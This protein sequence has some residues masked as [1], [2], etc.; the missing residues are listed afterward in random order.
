MKILID[1]NHPAHVHYFK[2]MI[3]IMKNSGV[4]FKIISRNKEIEHYLLDQYKISYIDRGVGGS[5][6]FS[7]FIYF[8]YA[9]YF[10]L[11][12]LF[13]FKPDY[14]I[15]FGTPYPAIAS[16]IMRIDH[17]SINDTEHAKLHHFL[18][19]PFSRVI[20]T[21]SCYKGS[22]GKKQIRFNSFMELSYLSDPYFV[23]SENIFNIL[24]INKTDKYVIIRFVSWN[25]VHDKGHTGLTLENKIKAVLEF[26]KYAK[27]FISSEGVLPEK[28]E[29]YRIKIPPEMMHDALAYS[30]LFYGESA[31]MASE[32]ICLGTPAIYLDNDGR[33][34]TDEQENKYNL[35]FNYNES[36][37]DQLASIK[38]GIEL[39]TEENFGLFKDRK[40][41]MLNDKIDLTK[42]L[43]WFFKNYPES[44]SIMKKNMDYDK[45]FK[46]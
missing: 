10:T 4:I 23:P 15:S 36:S 29:K 37:I 26:S 1:I 2:N 13:K 45:K 42:F 46:F 16:Y 33:G 11:I 25:A 21:P 8:F 39:L 35:V 31:T 30:S 3:K 7:K 32:S 5:S 27:V 9:I 24:K 43:I 14:V 34:Y 19:N 38:K 22:L 6:F 41:K 18:T 17:I 40:N 12:Q 28:L 44:I 20:L